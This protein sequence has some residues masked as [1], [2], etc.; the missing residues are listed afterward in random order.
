MMNIEMM[1]LLAIHRKIAKRKTTRTSLKIC[2][3]IFIFKCQHNLNY[4]PNDPRLH[5]RQ[6]SSMK[7]VPFT[8]S[9]TWRGL[10]D[11]SSAWSFLFGTSIYASLRCLLRY[12]G[13]NCDE[14]TIAPTTWT[15]FLPVFRNMPAFG[16]FNLPLPDERV[17]LNDSETV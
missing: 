5:R 7:R 3:K 13:W 17:N 2:C 16:I 14:D 4:T 10:S 15:H 11:S 12:T 6:V 8:W 9:T 1:I